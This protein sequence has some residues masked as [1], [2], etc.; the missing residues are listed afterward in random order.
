MILD[1]RLAGGTIIEE[2]KLTHEFRVSRTPLREALGR[3]EGEGFLYRQGRKLVVKPVT[4]RDFVEILHLRKILEGEGIVLAAGRIAATEIATIRRAL[5]SLKSPLSQTPEEHWA[6]DDLLHR[7]IAEASGNSLLS[8]TVSDLRRRTRPFSLRLAKERFHGS[9]KEH[10]AIIDALEAGD[11]SGAR[12]A[13]LT[14]LDNA[15]I[16]IMRKVEEI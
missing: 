10:V 4:L 7:T 12:E 8:R 14:H 1:G 15:K 6:I 16:H 9:L 2:R 3:L 13:I 11:T 5:Q